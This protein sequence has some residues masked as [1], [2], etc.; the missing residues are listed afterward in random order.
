MGLCVFSSSFSA[1]VAG[2]A[3]VCAVFVSS[4]LSAFS[5]SSRVLA[6]SVFLHG[7]QCVSFHCSVMADTTK[8]GGKK[9]RGI[10]LT[11]GNSCGRGLNSASLLVDC[12]GFFLC[13]SSVVDS[14]LL[15]FF[16]LAPGAMESRMWWRM[17]WVQKGIGR[18]SRAGI[19]RAGCSKELRL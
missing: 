11:S 14:S 1:C 12:F 6:W 19:V 8:R 18:V 17:Q 5:F 15:F 7:R 13:V 4:R 16:S 10:I 2:D 3:S 9:K